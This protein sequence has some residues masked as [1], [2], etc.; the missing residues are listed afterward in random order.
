MQTGDTEVAALGFTLDFT[1][2]VG[3]TGVQVTAVTD[4]SSV[5]F[6]E[7]A[8]TAPAV[9][10]YSDNANTGR[11]LIND[12]VTVS[13][14]V[15]EPL[16]GSPT[17]TIDGNAAT[18]GGAYPSYTASYTMQ[19]GDTEGVALGFTLDFTDAV[20]NAATQVI[21]TTDSSQVIFDESPPTAPSVTIFSNNANTGRA[22]INDIVTLSFTV[23]EPLLGSP[24]VT[25]DGNAATIGGSYPSYTATYTMQSGD[26]QVVALGFTLDF[27]DAVGNPA[28]QVTS[29]TDAS[30][31]I[32]DE[33]AP[34]APAVTIY[35]NNG[36]TGRAK[37]NDIVTLSFTV[38]E[39]LLGSPTVTID[40]NAATI[41]G[42][43]PSYTA[44]YTMQTGDTQVVALGFTLDFTDAVGNPGV[45]VTSVTD[46]SQVIFDE[47]LP[48][49]PSVT[50]YSD[51]ANTARAKINDVVTVSFTVDEPLLGN[52]TVT[53]DGNATTLGGAY[54][55]YTATYTMQTG[56]T[57][58][59]ALG[60]TIDLDDAAGNSAIQVTATTDASQVIF[61]ETAPTAP[62]VTIYSD[63]ANP[64][65][66]QVTDVVTLSFTVDEPLLGSPT[67]T[68]DGNATTIGGAYPSY[69]ASYTM[70][71][72]ETEGS[73]AFTLNFTD[74]VGNA[75]TQ[76]VATTDLST[77]T[78]DQTPPT[79]PTVTI[80]SNNG[81]TGRAKVNDIVTLSFTV[82]EPL[83]GNP[84]VTIDGNAATI[85]GA[86]PSYIATYTM[87][88]GDTEAVA[89]GFT[90]D[91]TDLSN[92]AATQVVSVTDASQVIFD[93]TAPTSPA[94]TIY[95]N[96]A[97][98][99]R[100]KVN[101]VVTLSFTVDEPLLGSPTVTIDGKATTIGG[102]YPSYT[103]TYTMQAGDTEVVALGFTLDFT[104]AVGNP[105][106][107]V[108]AVSDASQVIFDETLPTAPSVTIYSNNANPGR[109]LI[110]DVVT[111]SFTVDEALLGSPTVTIDGNAATLGGAYPSYTATYTM[112]TGDTEVVALGF[113]LDFT[114]AAGNAATQVAST[115]DAS[116]VIFDESV[117]T[118]PSVTIYSNNTNTG[119]A[120]VNDIVTLSF[121]V[122][123]PLLGNPTVTIDGN[124]ATIGGSYPSYTASYTMQTGDTQVVALGFTLDF[125][126]AVG[127]PAVQVTATTDASQVI[128]D[129]AAPTAP[130]VTI[131]SNNSNTGR[132]KVNDIVTLSFTVNEPLLG[133]PTVTIDGN[134]AT[135]GGAY[136]SYTA[137][138]TMQTGDTEAAALGFTLDFTDAVGNPGVQVTSVTDASQ[139]I[140]DETIPTAPSVVIYSNNAN[141]ARAK[142]GDTVT[143]SFTVNE[144]LL[145][146][147]TVAIDGRPTTIG[148]T[149]P[150]YTAS[151]TFMGGENEG[152]LSVALDFT[153]AAGN[154]GIQVTLTTDFSSVIF[155]ETDPTAPSV[156]IYSDNANPALA[157]VGDVVTLSFTVDEPLLGNPTVTI[158]GNATTIGGAYPSYTASYTMAGG[159]TA[160][161]LAFTLNFTDAVGNAAT[162]VVAT[163]DL[164][165]VTFDQTPPTA[166]TVTIY[167]NNSNTG[168]AKVNDV[169]TLSFTVDEPLLGSPTVTIDGNAATIGG[170]Y[171]SYTASY[172]MQT[173]DT[174]AVALG[175]TL[176]FTDVSG[177]AAVQ[178]TSVTDASEVIFDETAPTAPAVSIYSDNANS[179]RAKVNDVVT[180]SFTVSEPLLG[181]PT[182]TIDGKA[183]TIGGAYPSYTASYTMQTGD[184][185]VAALGFTLDLTDAAGNPG[186]QVTA[187]TDASSV[188][189]DETAPTAPAVTIYSD[190]ANTGRALINDVVTVSFTVNEP[191]LGSPTVTIDGNATTLGGSYPS[192]TASY[193]MQTGDT[194]GVALGFT[195]DFTDA[196]GN[197]ATQ[198]VSVTDA[199]QVIFDESDPTAPAVTIYSNNANP[200]R[201]KVNDIVTLSFTVDEPLLG[202]PTVTIDGN[203]ATIGGSYPSYTA[204][205]TMQSGDTQTV[206]LGF[207]L[208]FTDAVG[209][210]AV[211]V[212]ATTD[213]SQVI[214]D[215]AAPTAP[216]VTIYSN[217]TNT[218][219]AKV[220]DIVT[221][222]FTVSEPLLGSPT[223][224][225]DGNA[226]TISG[227]YPSYTATYTMQTGDTEAAALGFTLDFTDAV[228][229]P[230]VQ[231]TSATDASQVIFD[232]TLPTAP[233][234]VIY[235]NNG[236][237]GRAKVNDIVTLSFTVNEPL[238]GSP[239]V[240]IDG[241]AATIGGAYPSYT[242]SYTMQ[243]GD[244]QAVA[245]GFT[246]D[247]N[248]AAGNSAVQVSAVTDASSV[249]FDE[250]P[251]TAPI[252]TIYSNNANP[253][254]AKVNDVVTLSFTV[255]EPL[256]GNPTVTIDGN[257][258]TLG[259]AYPS[260]TAA[261]TVQTGDTAG[262]LGFT[263]DFTDAVGNPAVQVT[264]TT[265]SSS[266][267]FDE[268]PPT[269][270]SV[271]IYSNNANTGRAKV[272]DIVT[273]SFTVDEPLLGNPTVTIDGNAATIGGAY[274]SY[275]ATY[276]M[277]AG[278]T[279]S[280]ALTFT[281]DFTDLFS[282]AAVQVTSV[283]D[284]SEVI[285]D[286]TPPT[287]PAVSIY[288]DNANSSR[289]KVNDV[290]TLSFTV[291]EPLLGS[292]TVT[293]DGKA[294]TIGGAY[295]SYT[296]SYTMQTGDTEVVALG[297]TLDFD[298]AVGNSAVQV[299]SVTDASSVIFD[300]TAPAAPAVTIY[301][302]NADSSRAKIND[303]VTLSFTVNEPLLGS[304]TVT[305][306]GNAATIGG[307]YPS[308]TASYTMQSGDT[309]AVALGF[310]LDFT[311]AVG[312]AATQ[313]ASVTDASQVIFD[314]SVPTA[315]TVTIYS[316]N[317]NTSRAKVND[318]VTLSFT[319]SEPLLG[320]PTVTIDGNAATIGG[321][322][323]SYTAAYT[324][325]SGDTQVAALGFTLD[326][327]DAVGNP[328]VQVTST[329][330]ASQVIFDEA[331][332]T[333]PAVTIYS[334][335]G[336]T[337][338]AKVNDVVTLSFTVSEPLLGS[339]TVTIDGNAATIGGAYPSYTASYTMQTGDS[340]AAALGFT[341]DFT[342]AVGNPSVQV[343]SVT[344]AS[345]VIFDET[346]PTAPAV[347]IYS[348]NANSSRAK[349]NDV[350]T[351]SF[352]VSEPLLGSPT[353]T[354]DGNATTIG[355]AYP[356]YTAS[357]TMQTGD[358]Q[359]AALGFTLD[360][361]D[362][363][364]NLGVQVTS[365]SD[366]SQVIFDETAPTAPAV[367]IYSDNANPGRALINDVVTVSFT[368]DE[369][370]LGS[371]TVTIDGNAATLG[372]AYPSYNATYTM[373]TGDTQVVALGFTIDF[374]DAVGN[375]AVQVTSTTDASQVIFDE[376]APTAPSVSIYSNNANLGRAKVNDIVTLSFT[377]DEPLLGSPTVTIDGNA[378]TIGGSYPSYTATYTMQS[379]DTQAVALGFTLDFT[380]AVGNPAVQVTATTDASQVIFDEAAPTAPAVTIYSNNSNTGRAKVNDVVTLSFTVSEPLLGSPTVTIDGNAATIGG[381]YPS[382]TASYTMQT[383]DTE[384]AALGFTLD[385]TDAV[386]NPGVQVTSTTDASQ[387]IFDETIPTAPSVV[388]YSDNANSARAKVGDTVTLS[389]TVNEPLLGSPTVAID[390]RPTTIGGTYPSY[391]ASYTF[392][393]GENEGILSVALDFTDAAGNSGIQVTSTTDFSSVI[394]DETDPTAPSVTI[395]S[396]N[397]NPAL[398]QVGDVVTL[399]FTVDEPLLG[400]P[401]VTIDGNATTIGGAYPSYTASYTMAGGET[402][403]SLAFTLNFTD[404]VGNAAT[405]VVA[406]TDLS[407]V[408]F[409]Q[410]PP[411][412]PTVTIYS[413][414]SNT[415][416]AKVNDIV[417]LSFTVDEPLLG[418]PTVT[419]DG[420]AATIGGA[421]PSY[422]ATYTMQSGDTQAVALGF[423]LDFTDVSGNAAVQVTS[424]TDASEVIFDETAPTA[425]AVSIYSDNANSSRA[426]VN[427]VVTL[428]FTVSEPLLGSPTVTIDGKAAT[429]GGAYPSYTA[430]YTM[431]TGDTEVDALGF[432]LDLTDAV[433][434]P[435]VQVTA[436]TDA[437][438]VIFDETAPTAPAVTIYSDNANPGR[439]LINDVVTV[440]FTVDE[441]LLGSPTV[442]IDGN[443]TTLG[444]SYP[445]YTASY[446]MQTGDT[447]GVALGFT[448]DF[449]DAV[450]N[451]A[452]QVVSV[453]DASQVIF[454]ESD[455]TAPAVTIYSNN[456]NPGRAKVNDI[457][458]LSFTVDEPLLGSPTVTIDGNAATIGGSYPSYTASYTMQSGD[459][460]TVA[461]GFTLD[462]T[463]AVGNPA[464]QVTA[465]TD[466]SQ[467]IF[468]E[469]APTAPAVTI[470]SNNS[471][472]GRAKVNDIVTLS[473]TVNEPLLGSPTVTIDGNAAT[474]GGAYPSY[475]ASYTMQ[476]GDTE[477]AALGFT[478]DFTD[479]VGNPGV[480]VTSTT[481]ASQ[482]IFDE[483]IPT[484]PSV[485]IYSDNA[486]S[487]RAKVGDT[488]TL[489]FT[490]NEPLLGSPTVAID[491]RP[492]TIGGTY[493]SYT[494]SYTFIGGENEGS[495]SVALDFTDAAGNSGIQ[496]TLTTDFSS[497][498]FDETDP[499][500]P[501]VTIYSD[502]ADP[503]LAQVGDV[504]TLSF[505]VDEPLLGSP[506]V[507][508]DGNATTLGGAYP[509]YT[510]SYT[511][512][513]GETAGSLPFTLNF[514]DAVGNAATQV[515]ATTDLSTVS[516][517]QTPP[518]APT[519][520]IYSN[521]SNTGRAKVNDIVTL[522]FTVDEPLLGSPTVTIDGNAATIGGAY[523]SYTA[524]YT[525]QTGD[526][527]AVALGFTLDFTDVSGNAAVQVTSV[528]DA[529][530]VIFDETVP[531]APAV[532]IYSDNA[533]SSR[534][535]VNDVVTLSFTVSEPLLGSPTV[536]IDGKAATIG[537]AYPSYTASY[538]MQT[539][540]TEVAA[541]GFTLDL[542]DAAGNPGVQVTA[543]TDASSVIFDETA[544]TA[545]AVTIY[546]DNANPGRALI[547]DVVTVSFTVNE[548]LLGSPTVTIDG[549]AATIG[550]SYPSYT[551]SYTMQTGDTEGV[552]LGFTLDFTDA[553]GNAATQVVSVTDASQVIF[554]ESAP[555]A[556]SVTIYSNNANTGRA[557]VNDIV[558]VSFTVDE[559]LLGSPTVT[560]D[561]NAATLSGSYPSYNATYT[562]Q[563]GDTQVV[564]LGFTIDF[565][566]A[567][568]N[569]AVQVTSTTDASSVIFD[570]TDPT[571]P[572]VTIYSNNANNGRAKINDVV[573]VSFTVNEPLLGNPTVTIDGNATTLGGSYPSYTASYT[574][575]TGDTE[576]VALGFTL[577]FT[578]AVGNPA[579]QVVSVTDASQV[580]FDE[581]DPTALAV[582]I[583]SD[584]ANSSRAK[585]NDVVTLSFTVDEPLL[586]SP[587]VTIDGNA[588]TIGGSFPSYTASYTM[589][590]GDTEAVA[591]GFTLDFTDAAGNP[592]VQVTAVSDASQVIFDETAPTAPA[593]TIY[594]NN[595]NPAKAKV[596][597][598][599]TLSFTVDE[600]LL[601]NPTVT[602]DGNAATLGGAYPSYTAA[603][604]VQTG[605]TAGVLGFT[606]NFTDAVGN[607]AVQVTA[608]TDSSSVEFD[609]VPPTAPSVTIYSNNA[610]TGRAKVNDIVTL[611]FTVDEPLLGNPTVTIDGN[612]ATIGGAYPSYTATY[613]M[614]AGDTESVALTFTL[615]FTDLFSNAAVQVT[616]VTDASE[617]IFDETPPTAPA[618]SI[619][620]DNANSSRAKVNDVVTL[621]FTVNEPLLGSPTVTID[622]NATTIGG[623]YPSYTASYTM[624]SGDTEVAA[625]GFTLDLTDAVGNAGVQVTAVTDGS[626]VI[627]DQT[628][629]TAPAITIYSDNADTTRAQVNDIVTLSFTVDEPLLGN[630]TVTIDGNATTIGGAYPSYTASYTMQSG[631]TQA[632]ALGFTLDFTDAVGNA[633]TQVVSVTD[634]SQ[635]IFDEGPPTA[636]AVTIYSNNA[637]SSK[638]KIN[639]IV[640]LSFTVDEPLLGNPTVTIDGN[641]ATIGGSYPSYTATYTMQSGDT[642]VVALG[643]TLDFDDAVGNPA[644]QVTSTTDASQVIFD[645]T[646]PTASSV[647]IYSNNSNTGRAKVSDVVTV[648]FTVSEP[649]LGSP[650]V[651]IDGNAATIG[652][653]YP[654]YTASYT[655]QTGDSEAA[656][657]GFTLDFTDAAGNPG[658][659]VTSVSDASQVIFDETAP[660]ASAVTIYSDNADS[661]K[662]K[663]NDVVTVSFT[664]DEPLLGNPTVTIDGNATTIGGSYPSYTASYTMQTGDTEGVALGF[665]LDFNDAVGNSAVQVVA[666]TDASQVIFDETPPTAPVVSIFSDNSNPSRAKVNDVVTLSFTVSDPLLGSPT[667]TIDGNAA[668]IGGAYPSYTASY[669][670]QSGDTEVVALGFTLDF[671]DAVGNP[672]VQVTATTD[673]SQVIFDETAPTAPAVTIYSN[674]ANTGRAKINDVVTV[675]FTVNEPLLG[676]PTVTID[677]NA[678]TL[679]GSYPSYTASYTMQSG[680]T[681]GV[682][683]GFTLDFTDAVGNPATQVVSVTDASQVIFDE[684]DPTA[685]AVSI[686]SNNANTGRAKVN[687]IVTLS[688][689]VDEPLLGSPTVTI[690][691]KAATIGG[692]YP[693]YTASY[694]MQSGDTQAVALGFTL[695]FTDAV[696]N[697]GVQVTAVT[698]AS[699]VIF[700]E[701][702]PTAP[703]VTIY[704]DNADSTRAK[705]N[706][707]VTVSFTV[708]EPLLG[709]PTVTIDGNATTIGG[710]YPSYTATYTVQTGDT[711]G[712]LGFTLNFTDAVGNPATQVTATTDASSVEF[713]EV[714]PTAPSV[715]IYSNN[716]N[717]GRAK[718][719]DIVTVSFTVDEPL[720]GSPTVTI[721]GN[722]ATIGGSYPSYTATYT[723]QS[724]DTQVAALG[725][726]IDF[727]DLFSNAAVQVTATTDASQVI[728]DETAPTAPSITIY[729]NN[730][731]SSR[732]KV[733]D[734]VTL[735]FTVDEP[736][737]GSPTVTIDGNAATIGGAYP[738]YTASYTMQSG[739]TQAA[740]LGFTL[741]FTDAVG[742]PGVQVTAVTDASSVIFDESVP[743]A[744]S[745]TI[746]S[747][748]ANTG[749]AKVNDIV[750]LS[751]TVSE[752]LL[753]SPTVT[754]DGKAATIGGAY[755]SYTASYTMQTGDTQAVALGFTL[756]FDD[757]AG[758]S[759]VQVIAVTDASSVIFD[760]TAPTAV[761][762]SISSNNANNTALAKVND[763]VTLSFT[764]DEPLLGNPTVTIDGNATTL[765][766]AYPSYTATYT[767]Q[768]GDTEAVAL[769]FTLDFDDAAGNSAVQVT[770]VTDASQVI[771]D[772]TA[773]VLQFVDS[774]TGNGN[775]KDPAVIQVE[776][777]YDEA[778]IV[779]GTPSLTLETGA[780]DAV[781]NYSGATA[782]TLSFA[783]TVADG[784]NSTDLNYNSDINLNGGTVTDLAGNTAPVDIT[785]IAAADQLSGTNRRDIVVDTDE[786]AVARVSAAEAN[787]LFKLGDTVNVQ[788]IFDEVVTVNGGVPV[789][790]L[791][792]G[793]TD[794]AVA[795]SGGS[796]S[797]TLTFAYTVGVGDDNANLDY[798]AT[799][800][801][802]TGGA[803]IRDASGNDSAIVL[804]TPLTG[805]N[806]LTVQKDISVDGI[807]PTVTDVSINELD[808]EYGR[809]KPF[810]IWVVFSEA[811][812]ATGAPVLTMDLDGTPATFNATFT[813]GNGTNTL[814]FNY[815][816][817]ASG[818]VAADLD[819]LNT[820]SLTAGTSIQ[821]GH[822]NDADRTLA[823][824]GADAASISFNQDIEVK[825]V[826]PPDQITDLAT[827]GRSKTT[828]ELNWTAPSS[829][830]AITDYRVYYKLN[831][832][833]SWTLYNDGV[834]LDLNVTITGLSVS[835]DYTFMVQAYNGVFASVDSNI[836][837]ESTFPNDPFFDADTFQAY[838]LAG[839]SESQAVSFVDNNILSV[840]GTPILTLNAGET[841]RVTAPQGKVLV[842]TG[843]FYVAGRL[844][845]GG[846]TGNSD[847]GNVV[848]QTADWSGKE[849][850]FNASRSP[851]HKVI[852]RAFEGIADTTVSIYSGATLVAQQTNMSAG[853]TVELE[854][855]GTGSY[856]MTSNGTI[857]AY[858]YST[859]GT[860]GVRV[861]DPK[862]IVPKSL[863]IIGVPS[864]NAYISPDATGTLSWWDSATNTGTDPTVAVTEGATNTL[865]PGDTPDRNYT[866]QA[867]IIQH[868]SISIAARSTADS[869]GNCSAPFISTARMRRSFGINVDAHWVKFASIYPATVYQLNPDGTI[870]SFTL[871]KTGT[872]VNAPY[873]HYI[874]GDDTVQGVLE[875]TIFFS[876]ARMQMWY[877]P[878]ADTN[879]GFDN[880]AND[881]ETIMFGW[882][883]PVPNMQNISSKLYA[884]YDF[885]NKN[886]MFTDASCT[887]GNQT[888]ANGDRVRCVR[889]LSG[890][891]RDA[892]TAVAAER[893]T[894]KTGVTEFGT[895][896][897]L[898]FDG[899][900]NLLDFDISG[901]RGSNYTICA[902]VLRRNSNASSYVIG[903]N[904]TTSNE[905]LH[906]GY[907]SDTNLRLSHSNTDLDRTVNAYN[908]AAVTPA[909]ICAELDATGRFVVEKRDGVEKTGT[910]ATATQLSGTAQGRIG[911][912]DNGSG[913]DGEIGEVI[914]FNDDMTDAERLE[915]ENYLIKKWGVTGF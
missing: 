257:A 190:N 498:I 675:S 608:T 478:L 422:T 534:A 458:T 310:T 349:V 331:A 552:A 632:V 830:P 510:A 739:D 452:T 491:G 486:N 71:G 591:L 428:S 154:S 794:R 301:S 526:T 124:A 389:F 141:S 874:G 884:W 416:R 192:Y 164:S 811:V 475:T 137:T 907:S 705:V 819:Y 778:V 214:F 62:S 826:G 19:T 700:D 482:V 853:D 38:S 184:T 72:G 674:N 748:N 160:G 212:T 59:V 96:N 176:D 30:Q 713:D 764:V 770:A 91:F 249:I 97:N 837:N 644:V 751:F 433:G 366:A 854:V 692:S 87:Q 118:A 174:Q 533:N 159:E 412:A 521:N 776:V 420:K 260:Y 795:Y 361:T 657:L 183:A 156:T 515:V 716:A 108:T 752:P 892:T 779:S 414:N 511:M 600:P 905:G 255:D 11:A 664:V 250:T 797:D 584:N 468:D 841:G 606:L 882:D 786:P 394:F 391:T 634:A 663:V 597:D 831:G 891:L 889:D 731:N 53:I 73:L 540:D 253:A 554:D 495:L 196:V 370:L 10:I 566:D 878:D 558:T 296:A 894:L 858:Q 61:D 67:V 173:G 737:L 440:S 56:D 648:S 849:F 622:G 256:L 901:L 676:N 343:T 297:F 848:W 409:D 435:G 313:V 682:A 599:V 134:A 346:P 677:G 423:T 497:V 828:V 728:F 530:E 345:Q 568:G 589:Q 547:N 594:S 464:V 83:L 531:T 238:L 12:V 411:T 16:L 242:A 8:P 200:G 193:T 113:T 399:S 782:E 246:L 109:A 236:N 638:A 613:T 720:L 390:G 494:A 254:K 20:G 54:P 427:D 144:P 628:Q 684:S 95:S 396:D 418:S 758:N 327:T 868:A 518:T 362:A 477:A 79:A 277:Q 117:P 125:T 652:G 224:T 376:A 424:V 179:S 218:G 766:G 226:A 195:L 299:V 353:V 344:D 270:P 529:S 579:T 690:D 182:V 453:T 661:T 228:G 629:P 850:Y 130:A 47:V 225:I 538:T 784:H 98:S 285:F 803:T 337:G 637:D 912:A 900:N 667:V 527:E 754:I 462:F 84:T 374:T 166:P 581:S 40:G 325:Q 870:N 636:P 788:V 175:F 759:A 851:S 825:D 877:E 719:N 814:S 107:Q 885:N 862:P 280:V 681:E 709:D 263:L 403:G 743:T 484:A 324:M 809:N 432:T 21:A 645:E 503:A 227:S 897:G 77:V 434:N 322:Y 576:G 625:L 818:H 332:P 549:N 286:E 717:T 899:T 74:A 188:I 463:D 673:A 871:S 915:I 9:T 379:G 806:S 607:P 647:T 898:T 807:V 406:T 471:N 145:G 883:A 248:D 546:S 761:A 311:D 571:A 178:V 273:L 560:I 252:V 598:V 219:R 614:Q 106:I 378:A 425:P 639:D 55:N 29:T 26:T 726:T 842:G 678:T 363:A 601:G 381:A 244:T 913:F 839:T 587:T 466:A 519:V 555:A 439:A 448:L 202:S 618:V 116:Q 240:T 496:V 306:D 881:D 231:V 201:A 408:S 431:Q 574:M 410:T 442:T 896:N 203:A 76:I 796:P 317:A 136:P 131:Y 744:P 234:V 865:N 380:D 732:A 509:S 150:S 656:A 822:G 129:E 1:D 279:E 78:F 727:T 723:M 551:A 312:N 120:K 68:I 543:V 669:T 707:V 611:S 155:D 139:V 419:I 157:Q 146:S 838:N 222:S 355:G 75:A 128:F 143:L 384:A 691:G 609:E 245:L 415:G 834:S 364:G 572:A 655:M 350:V 522:S 651:T 320:S 465:T 6:D 2:A 102:A 762:V 229:N 725:F 372:G 694:T 122:D 619:Y 52:P 474:I 309:Q 810:E 730:A 60:F 401:T 873:D 914:I 264:A 621:S 485:V 101:D 358:T 385:F 872:N 198:V 402:A 338:R 768:T 493:P 426:K 633:A 342:D 204:T 126:D 48:T 321:S 823:T 565:T 127:N 259:G 221:L 340:E 593:V 42:S 559:P 910:D 724:G 398:A 616:S 642:E 556:S 698:D 640:T 867:M 430:N 620:S 115:T 857:L 64:A 472:T 187:V 258:A 488:V 504:V 444:G 375:P 672:A 869:D 624:Q 846:G 548:P 395:Y 520:T 829:T 397:A 689:T 447:E 833:P 17:V 785:T 679:G 114:D 821:D 88:A 852:V 670:M 32:F 119:R 507:T 757:A 328:A 855:T 688:F 417:T 294:A 686:Y 749:R 247:F 902:A 457:V 605:D 27:T 742:N 909:V 654:S 801:L 356:S 781:V 741:D 251:P 643:F 326:F 99:S 319:V 864:R 753:G 666:V 329:T 808:G 658:V 170:A 789:L 351:L 3:N 832:A 161:S 239:T 506:T 274:P 626:S 211:Q 562:M 298:D 649:L 799:N 756:D 760:E 816:T 276:T 4:V 697:P 268:I 771:F 323:P 735:S 517:D 300:E 570:E 316:N 265:D 24:T 293:I 388:I 695:D 461:L 22:K 569:P 307:A 262:A 359:A 500:A 282:N 369:P 194:E 456:A 100:A 746:Y 7:T 734:V 888:T 272:N 421:Y 701:I 41:S 237:T 14:T 407:T 437:S 683:L 180:L 499:T 135:I 392:I 86:Y 209:N 470:Y 45:Q 57:E 283:T 612:A 315:P 281:L 772:E 866:E 82:D 339:P 800:S 718:V 668:T 295:P 880:A 480:Q 481:D 824:P 780:S 502:N 798:V 290:V 400:S 610:N 172:T 722:A 693:S 103:A 665:T 215:E 413:N 185:E 804:D 199:S 441:P 336:N 110:N 142:V 63:N 812:S 367:T 232:E 473:F 469:A 490:V 138:Y 241:N 875:G 267:E 371:P 845:N 243:T 573:T 197:A 646:D 659:Q 714:P 220:N 787:G 840:D 738:S 292:P 354:I 773:P 132:A 711:A 382:Y 557:K 580:I 662:A 105:A 213:A 445:S 703:A 449:T 745:V 525:M 92:N 590:A 284:A 911:M 287:A 630:P 783:Y 450:G 44:S 90:L 171:P 330:D 49:A 523:P 595:A 163:T 377:V 586:G 765:L 635:V 112:Q 563:T 528:T 627:F 702:A 908:N 815:T 623:S 704:S 303:I 567:V 46:A 121:T 151:Y 706:D 603:Y 769:G 446:T 455:P 708:D 39:P 181:S 755:P 650:T 404:A 168:R 217:N 149:Y 36:N 585:V 476:T 575:Q 886:Y 904:S 588:A 85:G 140:F 777:H 501:S 550:G 733:N 373:Q 740:A 405:Q 615:D 544:P 65:L 451:A 348:D 903:T 167:S 710:A 750:T 524:S 817:G 25:I 70:V 334:N 33:A 582:S 660:T 861:E 37:V 454:D 539:G 147:P 793:T 5:I 148:G 314:E 186:V 205:Y 347:S 535:K 152:S 35:S 685:P 393:G 479:A 333:A 512:V 508:I 712:A 335:N 216:A 208:D 230:G 792:T 278:D 680:D 51:N 158:D 890:N 641:A 583:Y 387:V 537:G 111:V 542:T 687:D 18:L 729:S 165:T 721:D 592:S 836:V 536:T 360:F 308:Y 736:L 671:T 604:T 602:I 368:V 357:Y 271:T 827:A 189:F 13:F 859:S 460:Q 747:D 66:A 541:L 696:G 577:D 514:T 383:G 304:P 289:A 763:V 93:E 302:N 467:V 791:E 123:E 43:Y 767:M 893:P 89:L 191:L 169:V 31:V 699:S 177:N 162:Q 210:P 715:T 233:A 617:V 532:S 81:N 443:A 847:E 813:G 805:A 906:F 856:R 505:T 365:V 133:S 207:T 802:V 775:Y 513:G 459:T 223:V 492:T 820:T 835:T 429:I 104:D 774:T 436:V 318:I 291:N 386:G 487:A 28:V 69:T 153:D 23:D 80:Y 653:A 15:D 94:V 876:S 895:K 288:S 206:A 235:S 261:Y 266:V 34:T 489:S 438:S 275:T 483:T 305:I 50:I 860:Y 887:N 844:H 58:V 790:T 341:L 843:A 631:D 545:P 561:G 352:T 553:V 516:F 596:N 863:T 578:D 269:A 879:N 564:A